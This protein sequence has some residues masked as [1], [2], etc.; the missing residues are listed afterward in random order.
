MKLMIIDLNNLIFRAYYGM[1]PLSVDG[2]STQ[3]LY[4]SAKIIL[5]L[6]R[7]HNPDKLIIADESKNNFRSDLYVDYKKNR[8]KK[9]DDLRSQIKLVHEMVDLMNIKRISI[10]GYEADDVI[11]SA[12]EK[13]KN[14]FNEILIISSDKDLMQLVCDNVFMY[15]DLLKKKYTKKEVYE[16][17]QVN[18][19]QI[20]DYLS[21]VGDKSDNIPGMVGVG[22][23]G[24][25]EILK[26]CSSLENAFENPELFKHRKKIYEGL[27]IHKDLSLLSV[28]LVALVKDLNL[29]ISINEIDAKIVMNPQLKDFLLKYKLFS[30]INSI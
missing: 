8:S 18:P 24:A 22:D 27:T 17:F 9:P 19:E 4:G 5:N 12:V 10:D 1:K 28:K 3:A 16:K 26:A 6:L 25:L 29:D 13:F 23:K 20:H 30:I 2:Q 15:N 14:D 7:E 11:A 21:I